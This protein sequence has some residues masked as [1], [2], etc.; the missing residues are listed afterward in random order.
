MEDHWGRFH[1]ASTIA[2]YPHQILRS[3]FIRVF[4]NVSGLQTPQFSH[5]RIANWP[6]L[7]LPTTNGSHVRAIG[8]NGGFTNSDD[9]LLA[10]F[11]SVNVMN[12]PI[13][14]AAEYCCLPPVE[15]FELQCKARYLSLA[16]N[17]GATPCS[18]NQQRDIPIW[19][20][21][22]YTNVRL[23]YIGAEYTSTSLTSE[24][25][26]AAIPTHTAWMTSH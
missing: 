18:K 9:I 20:A 13:S 17:S 8:Y 7:L 25:F 19:V 3:S 16:I 21:L 15:K 26:L 6:E 2:A 10:D 22:I 23:L 12:A 11:W 5:G 4:Q 1:T 24:G 14:V